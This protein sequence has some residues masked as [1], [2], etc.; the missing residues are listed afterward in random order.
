[1]RAFLISAAFVAVLAPALAAGQD[2][3]SGEGPLAI[4]S[5]VVRES[6][7]DPG[8]F[9]AAPADSGFSKYDGGY[10]PAARSA[11]PRMYTFVADIGVDAALKDV[12]LALFMG[13]GDYPRDVWLNGVLLLRTG[14]HG[15]RYN[16]TVYY[17]SRILLPPQLLKYGASNRIAIEAYPAYETSPL[18]DFSIGNFYDITSMVFLRD[19]FNIHLVQA[20]VVAALAI[21]IFYFGS[22]RSRVGKNA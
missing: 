13:P 16:A 6:A 8:A 21:A 9:V 22:S 12:P 20:A 1:M 2:F 11:G 18:G 14:D 15:T 17:S 10:L 7:A 19:L 3:R 4:T 5:W